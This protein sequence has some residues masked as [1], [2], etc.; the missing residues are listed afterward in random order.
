MPRRDRKWGDVEPAPDAVRPYLDLN[1]DDI[2]A[3]V[4]RG[5]WMC[6]K[7]GLYPAPAATSCPGCG[8]PKPDDQ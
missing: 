8:T 3:L 7:C 2:K 4:R 5:N 6:M 1:A